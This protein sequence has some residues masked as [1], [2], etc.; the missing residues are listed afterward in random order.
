M[1]SEEHEK[2]FLGLS[3]DGFHLLCHKW[4]D[5]NFGVPSNIHGYDQWLN[6]F[7]ELPP[8]QIK[9]YLENGQ[10]LFST[11]AYSALRR[12][13][14][15]LSNPARID[16]I[17]QA[18]L[19]KPK[20]AKKTIK[21]LVR[22]GDKIGALRSVADDLAEKLDKGTGARDTAALARELSNVLDLIGE[23]ERRQG[24]SENTKLAKLIKRQRNAG[25]RRTSFKS[26][27]EVEDGEN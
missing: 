26:I 1:T 12:W 6:Y 22:E 24:P 15:I 10:E 19:A 17:Y 21:E 20:E 7:K 27:K 18:G 23:E 9:F 4:L 25:A 2:W 3:L 13:A 5:K 8:Y 16:K 11:E 14:D